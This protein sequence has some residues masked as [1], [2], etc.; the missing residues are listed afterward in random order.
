MFCNRSGPIV[1]FEGDELMGCVEHTVNFTNMSTE[2]FNCVWDFGDGT[3]GT[4]CAVVANNYQNAG[5]FDVTL[6]VTSAAGCTTAE[7]YL[8]Y[9]NVTPEPIAAFAYS[10]G[11]IDLVNTEVN[12]TNSSL[13]A[14][15]YTWSFGDNSAQS[16]AEN[17]THMFPEI[18]DRSYT[19]TLVAESLGCID[20]TSVIIYVQDQLLFFV[21]NI[22]TP[23]GNNI[24][25]KFLPVFSSGLDIYDYHLTIFNRWGELVFESYNVDYGWTGH[26]GTGGLVNDGTYVW[27]IDFGE[28]MTDKRHHNRGHVTVLK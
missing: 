10:P 9:I 5:L 19:V 6:T 15:N 24:N 4:G 25:N 26:F 2:Q 1:V 13:N 18:G 23:D 16:N 27:Q 7:T 12:F 8:D 28:T 3:T 21:P 11:E 20:Q 14:T 17:P 22:F